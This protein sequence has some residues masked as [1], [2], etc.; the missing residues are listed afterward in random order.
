[1]L[2]M[3]ANAHFCYDWQNG[4]KDNE[5]FL[6]SAPQK[7]D[8]EMPQQTPFSNAK[9]CRFDVHTTL[10]TCQKYIWN[11]ISKYVKASNS[12]SN[13]NNNKHWPTGHIF[14]HG[15]SNDMGRHRCG[16]Q[17]WWPMDNFDSISTENCSQCKMC[18]LSFFLCVY[19]GADALNIA[20]LYMISINHGYSVWR[21]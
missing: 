19:R 2:W 11:N 5:C 16:Q 4:K 20:G 14:S 9:C 1:M 15:N 17:N 18:S 3:K 12:N 6:I 10:T 13:D 21:R 8:T 7:H